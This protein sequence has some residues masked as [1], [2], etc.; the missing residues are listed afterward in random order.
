MEF[1]S[2]IFA[3]RKM[4]SFLG[5]VLMTLTNGQWNRGMLSSRTKSRLFCFRL[6]WTLFHI[7]PIC[8]V[9]RYSCMKCLQNIIFNTCTAFQRVLLATWLYSIVS[10]LK[11]KGYFLKIKWFRVNILKS[12]ISWDICVSRRL[13][14]VASIS[15]KNVANASQ[16]I[17]LSF[18]I[19]VKQLLVTFT[20]DSQDPSIQRLDGGLNFQSIF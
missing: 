19:F 15:V 17:G 8:N 9:G 11:Y 20:I 12:F 6:P 14:N 13:F 4:P 18:V 16:V 1:G 5:Y 2:L 10:G 3:E 7:L